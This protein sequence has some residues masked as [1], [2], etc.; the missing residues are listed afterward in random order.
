MTPEQAAAFIH[1]QSVAA[2]AEIEGMKAE[3][4]MRALNGDS[5]AYGYAQFSDIE[6]RYGLGHNTVCRLF[7]D[8]NGR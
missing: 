1:A 2:T 4:A 6:G 3:N 5:P 7:E 8:A